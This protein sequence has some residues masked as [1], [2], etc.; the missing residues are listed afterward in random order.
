[1]REKEE[2][3]SWKKIDTTRQIIWPAAKF[4]VKKDGVETPTAGHGP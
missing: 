2:L 4:L 1:M 3:E